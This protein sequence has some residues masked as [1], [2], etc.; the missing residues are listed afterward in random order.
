MNTGAAKRFVR[1]TC[2]ACGHVGEH[3]LLMR[4]DDALRMRGVA[5]VLACAS[6]G[7]RFLSSIHDSYDDELYSYY[8]DH[9][10][11][12]PDLLY[13]ELNRQ[14]Y[15]ALLEKLE[16]RTKGRTFL[17]VGCG[18]GA[19]VEA[20]TARGWQGYGIDLA[21]AAVAAGCRH[22]LPL[23]KMDFFSDEIAPESVDLVTMFEFIEHVPR[24]GAFLAR[25]Q[26][27]LKPG[28]LLFLTTPNYNSIDRL[29][30]GPDW[31]SIHVEHLTYFTPKTL[32]QLIRRETALKPVELTTRNISADLVRKF[33]PTPRQPAGPAD[34]SR[35]AVLEEKASVR[36]RVEGSTALRTLKHAVNMALDATRL[37]SSMTMTLVKPLADGTLPR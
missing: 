24:P 6:C 14:R 34:I 9:L 17:D 29:V 25:A 8:A 13:P 28:G 27:V 16:A 35:Q 31:E 10:H 37:G 36:H 32:R 19:F 22:G 30:L 7:T 33:L 15:F 23:R 2:N 11:S 1:D 18:L 26:T 3:R 4:K 21:E 5:D 12:D 20:A